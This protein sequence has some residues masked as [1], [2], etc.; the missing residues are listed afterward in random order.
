MRRANGSP[1]L[2]PRRSCLRWPAG[3]LTHERGLGAQRV[4]PRCVGARKWW[5]QNPN[6]K[7]L[8]PEAVLLNA[9]LHCFC[10]A[11]DG[12]SKGSSDVR[13][14]KHAAVGPR[15]HALTH[16]ELL[17]GSSSC[18]A[19]GEGPFLL[20]PQPRRGKGRSSQRILL[21]HPGEGLRGSVLPQPGTSQA[22]QHKKRKGGVRAG[23][24]RF[25]C[26]RQRSGIILDVAG[27]QGRLKSMEEAL[28]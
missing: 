22:T 17:S 3:Q 8:T 27:G 6:P 23:R 20:G 13:L 4:R 28:G 25:L 19:G 11:Q 21:P 24:E 10:R 18:F 9:S 7:G 14:R 26:P 15:S 2:S 12:S 1:A 16:N 5:N